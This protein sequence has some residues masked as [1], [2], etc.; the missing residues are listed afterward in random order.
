[1]ALRLD[2]RGR[3][4]AR[5][6]AASKE[7]A[8]VDRGRGAG[9][10]G[11]RLRRAVAARRARTEPRAARGPRRGGRVVLTAPEPVPGPGG[12]RRA[13]SHAAAAVAG[14]GAPPA[15]PRVRGHAG[16]RGHGLTGTRP[17]PVGAGDAVVE[18]G[19]APALAADLRARARR[20]ARGHHA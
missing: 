13:A 14:A 2:G 15:G 10:G 11:A 18:P 3:G 20:P 4:S 19:R 1:R 16:P 9:R 17:A 6:A 12:R 7:R 5:P 8:L